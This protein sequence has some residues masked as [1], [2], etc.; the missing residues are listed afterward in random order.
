MN[1]MLL[2]ALVLVLALIGGRV[3][4]FFG[5]PRITGYILTGLITGPAFAGLF[6]KDEVSHFHF[7]SEIA[8]GIIAFY[9]G[10]EFESSK[11]KKIRNTLPYFSA[12]EVIITSLMVF[13]ALLITLHDSPAKAA[14]LGILSIATAPAA[15]LLVIREMD[16]EGPITSHLTAMVGVNNLLCIIA[17]VVTLSFITRTPDGGIVM[18]LVSEIAHGLFIPLA[19]GVGTA[20]FLHYYLR[21]GLEDN[22]VLVVSLAA[23]LLGIGISHYFSVSVLLTNLVMGAFLVNTCDRTRTVIKGLSEVD[24]PLY[25]L[26]FTLAGASFHVEML[27]EMGLAG[28]IYILARAAGKILGTLAGRLS[29]RIDVPDG[30][31]LGMGLMPQAGLAIGLSSWAARELPEVGVPILSTVLATTVVFE[32]AGPVM[33]KM[34]LM[35]GGEVKIIKMLSIPTMGQIKTDLFAIRR[36]VAQA[37]GRKTAALPARDKGPLLVKHLMRYHIDTMP[38]DAPLDKVVK[39]MQNTRHTTLPVI[40]EGN[41]YAG[42]VSLSSI[43]DLQ[44]DRNLTRLIIK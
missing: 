7:I 25:V 11:F 31:Y 32:A 15:T 24:Y 26:F 10:T 17:F 23:I 19:I 35:R 21:R 44:F 9:I 2:L 3:G 29:G 6:T 12:G 37:L 41:S 13:L 34:S 22:E 18:P 14:L 1:Y 40:G 36:R 5:L 4:A 42:L 28:V 20:L 27:K 33:T 16:S 8:L 43:R 39:I 38:R 30:I